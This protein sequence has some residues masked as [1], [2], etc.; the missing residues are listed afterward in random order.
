[1]QDMAAAR[2]VG[3]G[4]FDPGT[5]SVTIG[6]LLGVTLVAFESLAV[7]TIAPLFAGQLD[8]LALYGWVFSALLL[9]SLLGAVAGGQLADSGSLA[10]PLIGGLAFFGLGLAISGAAPSMLQMLAGRVLQGLGGGALAT[11]MYAAITRA[12]PDSARAR[13][14]A[15][16]SSAWILPALLGPTLAGFVA[17]TFHWRY[18]FWGILPLVLVVGLLTVRPFLSLKSRAMV[19]PGR[20]RLQAAGALV[21]GAGL[22]L[23]GVGTE[24]P[25]LAVAL[26]VPGAMLAT[27]GLTRLT[28]SG[29]LRLR[30]GLP[31]VVAS[32]GTVFAAFVGVEAFL[33]L[34]LTSVHGYSTAVTGVVIA[35]GSISWAVGAWLQSRLDE[36]YAAKRPLR[37]LM[38]AGLLTLGIAA[39]LAALFTTSFPLAIVVA[40]WI[41]A[42]LGIGLAHTTASVLAFAL[43]PTGEEGRVSAALQVSDQFMAAVSTGVGGALLALATRLTWSERYGILLALCFVM[44]LALVA[45]I[46]SWRSAS[47]DVAKPGSQREPVRHPLP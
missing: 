7:V 13:M 11:V 36:S 18:V 21:L 44:L 5:R 43:A 38:G 27:A 3:R 25:W 29:T 6:I 45:L 30:R 28:P 14:M 47:R 9:A 1:M 17:Q 26:L 42:G 41:L 33:A 12:Y 31:S 22:F 23:V 40:G 16:T 24:E 8:G 15:L 19:K 2:P 32:R 34:M 4:V 46:A 10:Q 20:G 37:M 35:T 39:Q